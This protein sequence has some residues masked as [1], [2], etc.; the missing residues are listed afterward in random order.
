MNSF[1]EDVDDR[2]NG[3]ESAPIGRG[4]KSLKSVSGGYESTSGHQ[5]K[6]DEDL[7]DRRS[8]AIG[9]DWVT[10]EPQDGMPL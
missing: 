4:A 8:G 10:L 2:C 7:T 1:Y 3:V 9:L 5:F 6:L